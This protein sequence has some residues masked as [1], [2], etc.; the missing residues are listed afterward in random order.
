M[1]SKEMFNMF[2][3]M[4]TKELQILITMAIQY[5]NKNRQVEF[6]QIMKDIKNVHKLLEK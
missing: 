2:E 6:K 5:L 1:T 4:T 3:E